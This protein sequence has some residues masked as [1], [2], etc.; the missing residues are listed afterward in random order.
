[1]RWVSSS[2][3]PRLLF[4]RGRSF[5]EY[6][7]GQVGHIGR[8][9]WDT[10]ASHAGGPIRAQSLMP[11]VRHPGGTWIGAM[12]AK[13]RVPGYEEIDLTTIIWGSIRRFSFL[14]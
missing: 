4:L 1:M 5:G 3:S 14:K 6:Y 2:A 9:S 8:G 13:K 11:N 7:Q 10:S 12:G